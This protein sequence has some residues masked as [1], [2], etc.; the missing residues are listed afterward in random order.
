LSYSGGH[1]EG[2]EAF[3]NIYRNFLAL[4]LGCKLDGTEPTPEMLDFCRRWIKR[5][6]F[7]DNAVYHHN[8]IKNGPLRFVIK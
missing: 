7:I 3:A 6:A 5:M 1:P 2:L 8:R 4:T